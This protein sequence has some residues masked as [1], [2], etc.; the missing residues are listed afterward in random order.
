MSL[1]LDTAVSSFTSS[2]GVSPGGPIMSGIKA[3][4]DGYNARRDAAKK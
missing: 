4:I 1:G 3:V 2:L